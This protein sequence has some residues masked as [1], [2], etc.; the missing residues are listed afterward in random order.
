MAA[1]PIILPIL[2]ELE[3]YV[4]PLVVKLV[5]KIFPPKS[6]AVKFPVAVTFIQT[7][8]DGL[9]KLRGLTPAQVPAQDT[10]TA[11]W[12]QKLVDALNAAGQLKGAATVI[13]APATPPDLSTSVPA[14]AQPDARLML[15]L[16]VGL[17]PSLGGK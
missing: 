8:I 11:A 5:E 15:Q 7:L 13:D 6:G 4:A 10:T 14:L 12:V 16:L 17:L 3:P 9:A 2:A 1:L